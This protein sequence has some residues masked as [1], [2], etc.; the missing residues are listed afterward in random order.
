MLFYTDA[1]SHCEPRLQQAA[2]L[3]LKNLRVSSW[4]C[5]A[6]DIRVCPAGF[7]LPG[8]LGL[9][10]SVCHGSTLLIH[11]CQG[12][13]R[14]LWHLGVSDLPGTAR[15]MGNSGIF[16]GE[17]QCLTQQTSSISVSVSA[18]HLTVEI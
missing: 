9:G 14:Q 10:N 5:S 15:G 3:A 13:E 17:G 4:P 18:K 1:L 8:S 2:C 11:Y 7:E 12:M 16:S 6:Q